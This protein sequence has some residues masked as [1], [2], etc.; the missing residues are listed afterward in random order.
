MVYILLHELCRYVAIAS[1]DTSKNEPITITGIA[2]PENTT[3]KPI[4]L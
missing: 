4:I 2:T 3:D 1:L